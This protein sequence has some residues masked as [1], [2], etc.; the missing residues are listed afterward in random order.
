[1]VV[2]GSKSTNFMYNLEFNVG[3]D[4]KKTELKNKYIYWFV[5]QIR[6]K[7]IKIVVS[8]YCVFTGHFI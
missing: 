8:P 7:N 3:G 4:G 2:N 6:D 5:E 1:M